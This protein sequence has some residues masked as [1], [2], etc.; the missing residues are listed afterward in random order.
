MFD[1]IEQVQDKA[2]RW[3]W[4]YNHE[5]PNMA[6]GGITPMQAR[7]QT[8]VWSTGTRRFAPLLKSANNG[9]ITGDGALDFNN[10]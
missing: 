3:L 1:N 5:R 9:G 10:V 4:N 7:Q 6:F 2:T 8:N